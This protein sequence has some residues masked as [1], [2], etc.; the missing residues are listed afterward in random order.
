MVPQYKND[1][2][3][4]H[5]DRVVT[6]PGIREGTFEVQLMLDEGRVVDVGL[7]DNGDYDEVWGGRIVD[8]TDVCD[9]WEKIERSET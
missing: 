5:G 7:L 9:D 6:S 4:F 8:D 3:C 2:L 1:L